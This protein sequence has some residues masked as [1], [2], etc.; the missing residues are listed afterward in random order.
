MKLALK[1]LL[2]AC[3]VVAL[4]PAQAADYTLS[5]NTALT[6][7]DPL[8]KGLEAFRDTVAERFKAA[9]KRIQAQD[10]DSDGDKAEKSAPGRDAFGRRIAS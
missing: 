3:S 10:G 7:D 5:I 9:P 6:T 8:Y 4:Q 1:L 2:A